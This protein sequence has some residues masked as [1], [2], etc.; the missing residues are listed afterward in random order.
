MKVTEIIP[1][2][3]R[4]RAGIKRLRI[5]VKAGGEVVVTVPWRIPT[6]FAAEFVQKNATWI[7]RAKAKM[8]ATPPRNPQGSKAEYAK[9]KKEA[10]KV[11][12]ERL[13]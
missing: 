7:A 10:Q 6:G 11:F 1:Y 5:T 9:Y 12:L 4:R 8:A 13:C 2:T 3:V